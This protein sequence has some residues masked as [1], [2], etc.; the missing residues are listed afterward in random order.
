MGTYVIVGAGQVGTHVAELLAAAD[1]EV[2]VVTRSGSGPASPGIRLV[3]ADAADRAR[4][5]EIAKGAVALIN[6]A[7]P[8]YHR[9][10]SDWPPIAGSLLAAAEATGAVLVMTGNLYTYG[11]VDRPMTEDMPP[12]P[13]GVKGR[14]RTRIWADALAAHEAGRVR[15]T[16]VRSSDYFGPGCLDQTPVGERLMRPLLAGKP[17]RYAGDPEMPHSWTYV[18]DVARAAVTAADD[19]RAWG[20]AW[21]VPTSP[22]I[23]VRELAERACVIAGAPEPRV[24]V[25][26]HWM[27]RALGLVS[28]LLR[29]LEETR[30]QFVRP[31]A[32][33][34]AGF[35]AT[36]G[37]APTPM[38]QALAETV[39]WWRA[40]AA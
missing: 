10:V 1:H 19:E 6:C 28:P 2:T 31:F 17:V 32:V 38:D 7:G 30:Y 29:E 5:T 14:V 4:M 20:R 11:P 18:I 36:F 21:H 15:A 13:A 22:A 27:M 39:A 33:D 34:S 25:V 9:W 35:Q 40:R 3:T 23:S 16:E 24:G 12:A 26:P 8:P 37:L